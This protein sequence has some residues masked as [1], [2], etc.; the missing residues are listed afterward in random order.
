[1]IDHPM[2]RIVYAYNPNVESAR[3][4]KYLAELQSCVKGID[5]EVKRGLPTVGII[6]ESESHTLVVS[7]DYVV[8]QQQ[9]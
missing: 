6:P 2:S 9:T 4:D 3:Y 5:F 8:I 1:M 7:H